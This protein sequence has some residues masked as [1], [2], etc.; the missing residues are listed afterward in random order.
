MNLGLGG[1]S[2]RMTMKYDLEAIHHEIKADSSLYTCTLQNTDQL[3]HEYYI[4]FLIILYHKLCI[5]L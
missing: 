1:R 3:Y 5:S 2:I 4:T